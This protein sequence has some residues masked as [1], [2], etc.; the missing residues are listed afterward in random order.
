[1][2][3]L[4]A[5]NVR[6]DLEP[7]RLKLMQQKLSNLLFRIALG[8]VLLAGTTAVPNVR[9]AEQSSDGGTGSNSSMYELVEHNSVLNRRYEV[10]RRTLLQNPIGQ[11]RLSMDNCPRDRRLRRTLLTVSGHE[12]SGHRWANRLLAPLLT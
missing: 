6:I 10:S 5:G 2:K 9:M 11:I 12:L 4:C 3:K 1:M 7:T 8:L